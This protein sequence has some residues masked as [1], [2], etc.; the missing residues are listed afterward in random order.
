VSS[1]TSS[2]ITASPPRDGFGRADVVFEGVEQ[3][4]P[5]YG[6]LVFLNN[7]QADAS[8]APTAENGFAGGFHVYGFGAQTEPRPPG[9]GNAARSHA[10][11][12]ITASVI[13]TDAVR[14]ALAD[15]DELTVTVVPEPDVSPLQ[16]DRVSVV[17]DGL[18]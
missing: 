4:G 6:A 14:R 13:A 15:G 1:F 17:F 3:A 11:E 2:P 7:P 18:N 5:S 9:T 10:R 8:T 12:P 16:F